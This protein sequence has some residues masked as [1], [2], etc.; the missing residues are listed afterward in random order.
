MQV[1]LQNSNRASCKCNETVPCPFQ[2]GLI[3]DELQWDVLVASFSLLKLSRIF[4]ILS[5]FW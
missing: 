5:V 3:T 4:K 1:V 2:S